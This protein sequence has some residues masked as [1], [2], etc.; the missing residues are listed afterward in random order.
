MRL[1]RSAL[2]LGPLLLV[3]A[4]AVA[5]GSDDPPPQSA[6]P[7]AATAVTAGTQAPAGDVSV[8][9]GAAP[10]EK[11][12]REIKVGAASDL[13]RA[14]TALQP[15]IE[16]ACDTKLTFVFGSSGQLK[17]QILAG[18]DYHL[19][20]S[21]DTGFV[22]ELE[23]AGKLV[24]NGRAAYGVGRIVLAWRTGLP[25]LATVTDLTR[26]D[27]TRIAIANPAHAPYG[28]AAQ[29]ALT[30]AGVWSRLE[31]GLVLGENI[32]QTTDYVQQGNVDAAVVAL[33]LVIDTDTPYTLIEAVQHKPII[34]G[35][36]VVKD[37]GGELTGRC[38]LQQILDP[39]GQETLKRFGF[40][41]VPA[42]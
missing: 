10:S 26:A 35:G 20:L 19:Y 12:R 42:P 4:L 34:Q 23:R 37:T 16:Q 40:E 1:T 24:P 2:L 22:E 36:G 3:T 32:R 18:A 7:P 30:T 38:A 21:A 5:C 15:T 6:V 11:Q 41:A 27:I 39:A 31:R 13:R 25:P 29:E 14:M 9:T 8:L 17:E 28:R 33:A